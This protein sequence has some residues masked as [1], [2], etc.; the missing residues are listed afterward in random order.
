MNQPLPDF[1]QDK[2][3]R[4]GLILGLTI[5]EIM[6]LLIFVLLM[7]LAAALA[8]RDKRI[9]II[10]KGGASHLIEELQRAYPTAKTPDDYFKELK[11]AIDV[12][13]EVEQR[14]ADA[15]GKD[16]MEEANLGRKVKDAAE[17]AGQKDPEQFIADSAAAAKKG[18]KKGEW[19]PF[20]S[21]SDAGSA[22]P[23]STMRWSRNGTRASMELIMVILSTRMSSSSG[24]RT[25]KSWY[26]IAAA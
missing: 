24:S 12:R 4:R 9:E 14:G 10:D 18:R 6:I 26:A 7:A 17:A 25:M 1:R 20:F 16:L 8:N 2:Q 21:L 11:K 19:P 5:A 15:A 3:Y 13:K 23:S 22:K